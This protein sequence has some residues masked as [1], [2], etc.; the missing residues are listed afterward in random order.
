[1]WCSTDT[2]PSASTCFAGFVRRGPMQTGAPHRRLGW[3]ATAVFLELNGQPVSADDDEMFVLVMRV[4]EGTVD[5]EQSA[6]TLSG[7]SAALG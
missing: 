5:V 1:M 4:A 3:L 2:A 7:W 6:G